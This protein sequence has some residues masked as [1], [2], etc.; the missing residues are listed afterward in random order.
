MLESLQDLSDTKLLLRND[1]IALISRML[2]QELD[3]TSTSGHAPTTPGS[4]V[5]PTYQVPDGADVS[6]LQG[7]NWDLLIPNLDVT[8]PEMELHQLAQCV[9]DTNWG[10]FGMEWAGV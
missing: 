1:S 8:L 6:G 2:D 3:D 4:S 7:I 10:D 5:G 9:D